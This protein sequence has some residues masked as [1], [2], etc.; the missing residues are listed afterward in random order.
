MHPDAVPPQRPIIISLHMS[1]VM[2]TIVLFFLR[3]QNT[4]FSIQSK[5]ELLQ[6]ICR[7]FLCIILY[8]IMYFNLQ[9]LF[10]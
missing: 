2:G 10:H 6:G 9:L 3:T 1:P 8:S 4:R 5:V 7:L